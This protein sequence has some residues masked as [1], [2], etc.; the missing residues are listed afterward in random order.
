MIDDKREEHAKKVEMNNK[1]KHL[2]IVNFIHM[3]KTTSK[4]TSLVTCNC[5]IRKIFDCEDPLARD[6]V[7]I[8]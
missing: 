6:N 3:S 2:C 7:G 8:C 4:Q 1:R 5:T